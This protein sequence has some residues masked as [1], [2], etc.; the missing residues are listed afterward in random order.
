VNP[1][2]LQHSVLLNNYINVS[3]GMKHAALACLN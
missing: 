2:T 3:S 1:N